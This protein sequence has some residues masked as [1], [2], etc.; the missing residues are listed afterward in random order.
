VY[1]GCRR[2][3]ES[4]AKLIAAGLGITLASDL[5]Q[6][7]SPPHGVEIIRLDK[8]LQRTIVIVQLPHTAQRPTVGVVHE[9]F[10]RAA[11]QHGLP[12]P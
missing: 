3:F 6:S 5:G 7:F 12:P 4:C 1:T 9:A 10:T 8:P 11:A 2:S